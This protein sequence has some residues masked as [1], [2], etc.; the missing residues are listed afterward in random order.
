MKKKNLYIV[1]C[2]D[3]EGPLDEDLYATFERLEHIFHL[4]FKPS[5]ETLKK[6]QNAEINLLGKYN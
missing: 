2:I 6:L 5:F 4:K 3:T 1:H